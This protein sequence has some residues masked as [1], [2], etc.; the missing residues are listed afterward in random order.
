[1]ETGHVKGIVCEVGENG[2]VKVR[3]P[4]YDDMITDWLPV[5]QSLTYAL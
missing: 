2:T 3:L 1:M 4:E 5:L